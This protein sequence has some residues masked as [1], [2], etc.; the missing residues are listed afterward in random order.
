[1]DKDFS[2]SIFN[3]NLPQ[4]FIFFFIVV[5][6]ILVYF[7]QVQLNSAV[8]QAVILSLMFLAA[9]LAERQIVELRLIEKEKKILALQS[10]IEEARVNLNLIENYIQHCKEGAHLTQGTYDW[11]KPVFSAYDAYLFQA[12][13]GDRNLSRDIIEIYS[14]LQTCSAIVSAIQHFVIANNLNAQVITGGV[15]FIQKTVA[16]HNKQ[17]CDISQDLQKTMKP[18]IEKLEKKEIVLSS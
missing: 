12:C 2:K 1:M 8:W 3:K 6:G 11:N 17:L 9:Y 7:S 13:G 14:K 10:L 4:F 16:Y 18:L 5:L 15:E